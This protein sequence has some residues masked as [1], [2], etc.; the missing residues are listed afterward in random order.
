MRNKKSNTQR[1]DG[2][3][4]ELKM[5]TRCRVWGRLGT[6]KMTW[7][8]GYRWYPAQLTVSRDGLN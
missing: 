6:M 2:G 5:Q 3:E 7:S 8:R 4:S 1:A